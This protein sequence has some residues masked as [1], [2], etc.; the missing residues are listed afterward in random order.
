MRDKLFVLPLCRSLPGLDSFKRGRAV[1]YRERSPN[2]LT[3]QL[4]ELSGV[5]IPPGS[6]N[7]PLKERSAQVLSLR[8]LCSSL[9]S[10]KRRR[11][12]RILD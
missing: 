12:F 3:A 7:N 11:F 2:S 4:V 6:E 8:S 10:F 5:G 1:K 9:C